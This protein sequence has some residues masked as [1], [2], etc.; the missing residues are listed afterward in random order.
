M[1]YPLLRVASD[2]HLEAFR[3]VNAEALSLDFVPRDDRDNDSILLLAGDISADPAQLFV[4]LQLMNDRF[5][6]VFFVPGNHEYYKHEY[7]AWG[8]TMRDRFIDHGVGANVHWA[9]DEVN[10]KITDGIRFIYGT[11]WGDGGFTDLDRNTVG[12]YLN[13]FRLIQ[14]GT[15][16]FSVDDMIVLYKRQRAQILGALEVP[17]DG[18]TVVMTHHLPS[19]RLVSERFL[20]RDGTDG[21]NGGF[22]GDCDLLLAFDQHPDLWVHGHTHDTFDTKLWET[23]IICNPAGYRGEW[24]T[25]PH[26]T[27]MKV[28]LRENGTKR[29]IAVPKFVEL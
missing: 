17:F 1:T 6:K 9:F 20:T 13:D 21:A 10:V 26:N 3:G 7:F 27:Y 16:K 29:A 28:E 23:H 12:R 15:G 18:K 22:V 8:D 19:R 4:F 25:P 2:L 5:K 11:L 24:A 14:Y